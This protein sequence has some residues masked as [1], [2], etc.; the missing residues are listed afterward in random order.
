MR[1][2]IP[3]HAGHI[4]ALCASRAVGQGPPENLPGAFPGCAAPGSDEEE[5]S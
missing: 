2:V 1:I 4:P 5:L 3:P